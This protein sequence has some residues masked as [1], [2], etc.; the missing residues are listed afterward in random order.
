MTESWLATLRAAAKLAPS[1]AGCD[2]LGRMSGRGGREE[3]GRGAIPNDVLSVR[4]VSPTA[5][6]LIP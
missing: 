1:Q 5:R 2:R 3:V 6:T 4:L